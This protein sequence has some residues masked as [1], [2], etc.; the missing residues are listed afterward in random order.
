M[1]KE[2]VRPPSHHFPHVPRVPSGST[3]SK[4]GHLQSLFFYG[5]IRQSLA[6]GP[7]C[8]SSV[9]TQLLQELLAA[10]A[11]E[12]ESGRGGT[13]GCHRRRTFPALCS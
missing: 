10:S 9:E 1:F 6:N 12:R 7:R 5:W 8:V 4:M 13:P 2:C 3:H 11:P